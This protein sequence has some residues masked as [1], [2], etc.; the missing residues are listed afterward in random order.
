MLRFGHE[1]LIAWVV[2]SPC[3]TDFGIFVAE[4]QSWYRLLMTELNNSKYKH[5]NSYHFEQQKDPDQS[6]DSV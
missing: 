4:S 6:Y 5:G 3:I 2:G 1:Y